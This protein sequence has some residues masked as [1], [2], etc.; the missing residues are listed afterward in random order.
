MDGEALQAL[1][2]P[3]I[4]ERLAAAAATDLGAALA[5]ALSPSA[6]ADEV[7]ARQA[8]TAEAVALLDE[9]RRPA[10]RGR[11]RHRVVRRARRARRRCSRPP[12]CAR[13]SVVRARRGR[14]A[15][16][17]ARASRRRAAARG[18]RGADRAVARR[19][20]RE[21]I[22][23]CVEE[24]GSDLRDDASPKLRKLR[25]EVRNGD[26]RLRDELAR[27]ARSAGVRDA[28][29]E[30]FLAERGGR[31]VLAVRASSRDQVPGIVHDASG[32]GQTVF[33]EP[34]AV[35]ELGNRL[36]EAAAEAR[37]EAERILRE[38]S[39]DV[40]GRGDALRAL[41][42]A[43]AELDL[44][45]ARGSLSRSW[46]GA[47]VRSLRRG[48][49]RRCAP[50]AA[51]PRD[52]RAD[53]SR[54]RRSPRARDQRPE[55]RRQDG[56]AEDARPR[57]AAPPVRAAPAGRRGGAAG[58]RRGARR[59]RRPAVDR[60]EPLDV[61]R[62][63]AHARRDPRV[64]DRTVAR[65]A[66]RGRGRHRSRG[67]LGARAGARRAARGTGAA[68]RRDDALRRAEGVGERTC[69]RRERRDRLRRRGGHAAVP[70]RA[71]PAREPRTRFAS[72]S[73]SGSTPRS[74]RDARSRVAPERLR[75]AELVA[76]AETAERA[77]RERRAE[78]EETAR[79][80]TAREAELERE[81]ERVRA[82][83]EQ[84]RTAGGRRR[85]ARARGS[86]RGDRRAARRGARRAPRAP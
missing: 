3:A 8:L 78:V 26:A 58:V 32:S 56:R 73:G 13:S 10:A 50:S 15:P 35:V 40:A 17:R 42:A 70:A 34:L 52:G 80:V 84:A 14:R 23:R 45:L 68:D 54:P 1:E 36:A 81:L 2:L 83:V 72:R 48:A 5:R 16:R 9:R 7:A 63:R 25:R 21:A 77:A 79:R 11:H 82:S 57:R 69:R 43:V 46:H 33:V 37:E 20:S 75:A 71:R 53:R 41:V 6:A 76:E 74:S 55:H 64:G 38:L 24:D 49:P 85:R 4:L 18:D 39:A 28:L 44:A 47:E 65:A 66:R 60:D 51:R 12:S 27:I 61:L 31:P 59:H 62:P 86:T 19:S 29:Q 30:S 67:G 22:D